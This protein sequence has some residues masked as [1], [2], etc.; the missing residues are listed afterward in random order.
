MKILVLGGNGLI[1]QKIVEK[2]KNQF[3]IISTHNKKS[4]SKNVQSVKI[5]LPDDFILLKKLIEKEKPNIIINTMA[6]S[7]LDFC[8]ENRD[9]VFS[10]HVD[11]TNKISA[12]CSKINSKIIFISTDYVFDGNQKKKYVEDDEP[13][14]INYY[15]ET[16][17]LAERIVLKDPKNVV[18]RTSLV[19][20]YGERVRFMKYVIE[21]LKNQEKIFA[22][23]DIFN[24]ATNIDEFVESVEKVIENDASG[25]FHMVGSSC[26][27]RYD[28]AKKN[29]KN[30]WF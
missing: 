14:P 25:I 18:L 3:T 8:E 1:G 22:Y 2:L 5:S 28:F 30:I 20:G 26:I 17:L 19:Y 15:G 23:N 9:E 12:I 4:P 13:N 7:N 21:N 6:Y 10:L 29:S 27:T 24:S 11:I 16:K